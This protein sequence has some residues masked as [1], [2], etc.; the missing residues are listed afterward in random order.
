MFRANNSNPGEGLEKSAAVRE[1]ATQTPEL[2]SY[3]VVFTIRAA[4]AK[5]TSDSFSRI[6]QLAELEPTESAERHF[7]SQPKEPWLLIIDGADDPSLDLTSLFPMGETAY[8]I[9]TT[10]NLDFR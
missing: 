6:G 1:I 9:I 2:C 4:S 3:D 5:T 8:I 7:L 10:R